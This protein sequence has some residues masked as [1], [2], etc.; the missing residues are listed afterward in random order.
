[1]NIQIALDYVRYDMEYDPN[2]LY[3]GLYMDIC[4]V[5]LKKFLY[6][7]IDLD[8]GYI[9]KDKGKYYVVAYIGDD[10]DYDIDRLKRNYEKLDS[11]LKKYF[12]ID[13]DDCIYFEAINNGN[14]QYALTYNIAYLKIEFTGIDSR[15]D[16]VYLD[17]IRKLLEK[18]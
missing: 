1:M 8:D 14:K 15:E 13:F 4:S 6:D 12:K 18:N 3:E 2:H 11:R 10:S 16:M 9:A 5:I 17:T 7:K